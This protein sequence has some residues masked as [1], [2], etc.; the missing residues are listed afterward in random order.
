MR[1]LT[2][3]K[4]KRTQ[5][6]S[7]TQRR[8]RGFVDL[9]QNG[10]LCLFNIRHFSSTNCSEVMSKRT[11]K[12]AG[13]ERVTAKSK[14]MINLDSRCS[15]RTPDVLPST[16]SQ[17]PGKTRHESQIPLSPQIEQHNRKARPVVNA[18]SS[19][20]SERN[21]DDDDVDSKTAQGD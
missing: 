17:S 20:Y 18:Y 15:E 5:Q 8:S 6:P 4:R 21:V 12:D 1:R 7:S 16:A 11:P 9:S 10:L 13:E 2:E 19:N 14:P 3:C